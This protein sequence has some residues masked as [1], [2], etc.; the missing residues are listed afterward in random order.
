MAIEYVNHRSRKVA[1]PRLEPFEVWLIH[2]LSW[3]V[4]NPPDVLNI[5]WTSS[6]SKKSNRLLEA[7]QVALLQGFGNGQS[8]ALATKVAATDPKPAD[9][10]SSNPRL[11]L[12]PRRRTI[13][14]R[15]WLR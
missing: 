1:H 10:G 8:V 3:I 14:L 7:P 12:S 13:A 15:A 4:R 6:H 2:E 9:A 11:S 5:G